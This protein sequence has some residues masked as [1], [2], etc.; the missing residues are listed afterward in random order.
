M[1]WILGTKTNNKSNKLDNHEVLDQASGTRIY[2]EKQI[3]ELCALHALNNLFQENFFTKT[4][5]DQI[6]EQ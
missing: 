5:L 6:C 2:H 4:I 1:D 3:K